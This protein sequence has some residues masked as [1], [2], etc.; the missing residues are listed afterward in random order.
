M[1]TTSHPSIGLPALNTLML[2]CTLMW[3]VAQQN[4]LA[5]SAHKYGLADVAKAM[6]LQPRTPPPLLDPDQID[7]NVQEA[8]THWDFWPHH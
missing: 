8:E 4:G 7:I 1:R 5:P 3:F 6:H 2:A